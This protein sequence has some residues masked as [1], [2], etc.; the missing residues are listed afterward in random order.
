MR[1]QGQEKV[2]C[3]TVL[4]HIAMLGKGKIVIHHAMVM[5]MLQYPPIHSY[6][7]RLCGRASASVRAH[8]HAR[9]LLCYP[10]HWCVVICDVAPHYHIIGLVIK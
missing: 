5:S 1:Q 2:Q 7:L 9:M 4:K 10:S 8:R 3:N 6:C